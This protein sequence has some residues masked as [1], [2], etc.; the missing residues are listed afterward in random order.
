MVLEEIQLPTSIR[1]FATLKWC[2]A[3]ALAVGE[4]STW[5]LVLLVGCKQSMVDNVNER[6]IFV[7]HH[8]QMI[9]N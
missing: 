5:L 7:V 4:D 6:L 2:N 8:G 9:A 3:I 1:Y